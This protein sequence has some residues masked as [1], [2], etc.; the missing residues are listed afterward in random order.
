MPTSRLV[1]IAGNWKMHK[2]I[3]EAVVFVQELLPL[4]RNT[5]A[6]VYLAVPFTCLRA[7]AAASGS[8]ITVGAQNIHEDQMGAF[9]GEI[10]AR[11]VKDTGARFV[12]LGHS[13]RRR[14]FHESDGVINQKIH[15]AYRE[16]LQP[17]LCIGE[18]HEER[19]KGESHAVL[20]RQLVAGLKD[21]TPQQAENLILAYEPVW[22]IGTKETATTAIIDEAHGACRQ[23]LKE[24]F[25]DP[26]ANQIPILY[27][28]SVTA[29]NGKTLIDDAEIDGVLV[30]GASLSVK[31]FSQIV[32]YQSNSR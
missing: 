5:T 30:G 22:A 1:I 16:E 8:A 14:L 13:E 15:S 23:V 10:S 9:T 20:K 29:E 17:L 4:I 7:V 26:I 3:T 21:V 2:T 19:H 28:G 18:T 32:N 25:G 6:K 31:S 27:G 12:I 24:L 11:M